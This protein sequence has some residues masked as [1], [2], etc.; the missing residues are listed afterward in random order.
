VS[1]WLDWTQTNRTIWLATIA[2]GDDIA[3]PT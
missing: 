1:R 2:R 3:D